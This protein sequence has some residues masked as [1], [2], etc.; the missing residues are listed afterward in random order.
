MAI[1][2]PVIADADIIQDTA[3]AIQEKDHG[4]KMEFPDIPSR[5][6]ALPTNLI[7]KTITQNGVY[8][9]SSDNADGYDV[10]TVDVDNIYEEVDENAPLVFMDWE[11]T[12][13]KAYTYS[14]VMALTSLPNYSE[15]NYRVDPFYH[16]GM[17]FQGW[18]WSLAGIK[19]KVQKEP[20]GNLIVGAMV[21]ASDGVN[22]NYYYDN[23]LSNV[24]AGLM[25]VKRGSTANIGNNAYPN[26]T[27]LKAVNIPYGVSNIGVAFIQNSYCIVGIVIPQN[28]V[29]NASAIFSSS[30]LK[31]ISLPE[32]YTISSGSNLNLSYM[33]NLKEGII[34][35]GVNKI[36]TNYGFINNYLMQKIHIPSTITSLGNYVFENCN[37]L[38]YILLEGTPTLGGTGSFTGN[39]SNQ[40]IYVPRAN[41]SF[42]E[43]ETN[44]SSIYSSTRFQAIEDNIELLER[45]G[46]DVSAYKG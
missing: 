1:N 43:T 15:I 33:Y 42:F 38:L 39:P 16:E 11:G 29:L 5:I 7:P 18:N 12:L 30:S 2:N 13:L 9:A 28:I 21:I 19:E 23:K 22:H 4:G 8:N 46:W 32:N 34:Y 3:V 41:L 6:R 31:R 17:T 37:S 20:Y 35:K 27:G 44:W 25:V 40:I 14:E 24:N 26:K 45:L 10:V 36:S